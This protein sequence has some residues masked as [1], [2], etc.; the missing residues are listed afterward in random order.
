VPPLHLPTPQG[1][2]A[3][4]KGT[5]DQSRRMT[6]SAAV[7]PCLRSPRPARVGGRAGSPPAGAS[8]VT[9]SA[10]QSLAAA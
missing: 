6:A 10:G 5:E 9:V 4:L 3:Y 7:S 1:P 8:W 2:S